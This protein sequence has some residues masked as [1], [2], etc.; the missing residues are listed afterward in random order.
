MPATSFA[1]K[2]KYNVRIQTDCPQC[3][4]KNLLFV[5]P[6]HVFRVTQTDS[7]STTHPSQSGQTI[8]PTPHRHTQCNIPSCHV[9][10]AQPTGDSRSSHRWG[11]PCVTCG[12]TKTRDGFHR[13]RGGG[14]FL[15]EMHTPRCARHPRSTNHTPNTQ[16]HTTARH[17]IRRDT[18]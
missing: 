18:A 1:A 7:S 12:I 15:W 3:Q 5:T 6:L 9:Q 13:L 10:V 4:K 16:H 17:M 2:R 14:V 11:T 8:V